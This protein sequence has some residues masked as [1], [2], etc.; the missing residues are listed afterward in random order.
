MSFDARQMIDV[1]REALL[2]AAE[3]S[4]LPQPRL[5]LSVATWGRGC[6]QSTL[7][8]LEPYRHGLGFNGSVVAAV[9]RE[10]GAEILERP[11]LLDPSPPPNK[12]V[13]AVGVVYKD[14]HVEWI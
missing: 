2:E 8:A 14:V 6:K 13:Q 7:R 4:G 10:L 3:R 11:D 12:T 1:N 5:V 9:P